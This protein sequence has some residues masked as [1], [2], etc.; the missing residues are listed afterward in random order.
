V[1]RWIAWGALAVAAGGGV[2][3][4]GYFRGAKRFAVVEPGVLLRSGRF[5][6]A[7]LPELVRAHGLRTVFSFTFSK[8]ADE[9]AACDRLG[10][11]RHFHYLAGDGVGPDEPYLRF[12]EVVADPAN[13][14]VLVHCSAGVQ[15]TGGAVALFRM[16][17]QGWTWEAANAEMRAAGNDGNAPQQRQLT[18]LAARRRSA[19][20]L[21]AEAAAR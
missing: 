4:W 15:R 8:D 11:R 6:P 3:G 7:Q 20:A 17:H 5:D 19:L 12:L 14:P 9:Q 18:A 10:I 13:H 21:H 16:L 2:W 1:R